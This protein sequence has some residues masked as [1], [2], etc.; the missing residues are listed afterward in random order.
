MLKRDADALSRWPMTGT[1]T[2]TGALVRLILR[3]D[4]LVMPIWLVALSGL[5]A[6]VAVSFDNL[7][8]TAAK[9]LAFAESVNR[10]PAEV[11][12]LGRVY[13][14]SLGGLTAWRMTGPGLIGAGLASLLTVTRH[15]RREEETGRRE[16]LGATVVG[17]HA[18]L[19]AA[20]LVTFGANLVV[21]LLTAALLVGV[22]L[23]AS[24]SVALGFEVAAAGCI[25]AALAGLVAQ[26]T[27]SA[28]AAN[29]IVGA[30]LGGLYLLRVIGDGAGEGGG[31][32][33]LTWLSPFGLLTRIRAYGD[34]RWWLFVLLVGLVAVLGV[35]SYVAS[36]RRD[37]GAGLLPARQG[38]VGASPWLR[39]PLA[40]AWRLQRGTLLAW[41]AS[42][43]AAG[44][45]LGSNVN[46]LTEQLGANPQVM[47]LF[48]TIGKDASPSN[49]LFAIYLMAFGPIIAAY[50][51]QGI[52]RL[53]SEEDEGRAEALLAGPVPRW[54]WMGGH[55]LISSLGSTLIFILFGL[56]GGLAYGL[57]SGAGVGGEIIRVLAAALAYVPAVW[58]LAG[59]SAALFGFLP[60]F[61]AFVSWS[62]LVGCLLID[63]L[64]EFD[65]VSQKVQD[66]SP[67]GHVPKL[68]VEDVAAGPL[69]WLALIAATLATLG[70]MGLRRRDVL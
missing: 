65:L 66:I 43:A 52:L 10:N 39:S 45:L 13:D 46:A 44:V 48:S 31:A 23:P 56:T 11:L 64:A 53:C 62:A 16:L 41:C 5:A 18:P 55:V 58:V 22:G 61:A 35:S 28:R 3:R 24:G 37:L 7:Y 8:P 20:L 12:L 32:S 70:L 14:P 29:G 33:W 50:A 36:W 34:E 40:L 9:L 1:F 25:F 63:L 30:C 69:L 27:A 38:P 6:L 60:R 15:T 4:R 21:A 57:S 17:R 54:R 68:L 59:I 67:F 26:L 42:V 51:V 49:R 2:G 19:T 47:Q